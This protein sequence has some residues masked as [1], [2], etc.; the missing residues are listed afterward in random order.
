MERKFCVFIGPTEV[1]R[2]QF[3]NFSFY[4]P[5]QLGSVFHAVRGGYTDI[6]IVDGVFGNV[7]AVWHKEIL[8][9]LDKGVAVYG[10]ASMGALRAAELSKFGMIGYGKIY[11]LYRKT[12]LTN[13]DEVCVTH[14]PPEYGYKP[15]SEP[16]V[17][18]RFFLRFLRRRGLIGAKDEGKIIEALQSLHFSQRTKA[19]A[20]E[21]MNAH[22][23]PA[24]F[25][26]IEAKFV[27]LYQDIK[28]S[29]ATDLLTRIRDNRIC[30]KSSTDKWSFPSTNHWMFQFEMNVEEIPVLKA[31]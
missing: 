30:G 4:Q 12:A 15:F 5:A 10:A 21:I 3:P 13:D 19:M 25:A 9:A 17:N 23:A 20:L 29:D 26:E 22:L 18:F 24:S 31:Y 1:D 2:S 16:L 11:Q 28:R 7:P 8:Y 6:C 14:A 27:D